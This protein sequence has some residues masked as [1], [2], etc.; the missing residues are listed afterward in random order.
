VETYEEHRIHNELLGEDMS[1]EHEGHVS[2]GG[3]RDVVELDIDPLKIELLREAPH[4]YY[5]ITSISGRA[6]TGVKTGHRSKGKHKETKILMKNTVT[7]VEAVS[8]KI[9]T[10]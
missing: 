3:D 8:G 10:Q 9:T 5:F 1:E 7:D 2:R 4:G 6:S